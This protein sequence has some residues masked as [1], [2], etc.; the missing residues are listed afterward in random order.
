MDLF[1]CSLKKIIGMLP[2]YR[3]LL[4][5]KQKQW[6]GANLNAKQIYA[7]KYYI[8]REVLSDVSK[9]HKRDMLH[10]DIKDDNALVSYG[11]LVALADY[12]RVVKSSEECFGTAGWYGRQGSMLGYKAD[13]GALGLLFFRIFFGLTI[14]DEIRSF[15]QEH[16]KDKV[17][18]S[19]HSTKG[20]QWQLQKKL[21]K[22]K[23]ENSHLENALK[24]KQEKKLQ[25]RKVDVK[26]ARDMYGGNLDRKKKEQEQWLDVAEIWDASSLARIPGLPVKVSQADAEVIRFILKYMS[27]S[28][29]TTNKTTI[30]LEHLVAK[31]FKGI[32]PEGIKKNLVSLV[33]S[34]I[35]GKELYISQLRGA[36]AKLRRLM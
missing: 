25:K 26:I 7:L 34:E 18:S 20:D 8:F 12:G 27:R 6:T 5:G 29:E 4:E 19:I 3:Q 14:S 22:L 9:L 16:S 24:I 2:T 31:V 17:Y 1:A 28:D 15:F 33:K 23:Q 30:D 11:G 13:L 36:Y 10:S 32:S 35:G 21:E